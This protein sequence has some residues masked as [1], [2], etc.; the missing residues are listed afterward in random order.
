MKREKSVTYDIPEL[1]NNN[2]H[3]IYFLINYALKFKF[4]NILFS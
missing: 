1:K 4:N 3:K 2:W